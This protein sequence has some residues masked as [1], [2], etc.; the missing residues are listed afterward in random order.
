MI[1]VE[2]LSKS[3]GPHQAV[4]D[5]SF[6]VNQGEIVGFLGPNGAGKSTTL[7]ILA[8][9]LGATSGRVR[10]AGYDIAEE[11]MR[12]RA[13]LGYMP[14]TSPLY[15]EM[16]VSE[17][18][19]FRAE[20]KLV[21]RRA[22]RDAVARALRDARVEDVASVMIGHLSK[23][24]RQRVGLADALVGDPPLLILDEPTAGLDPNQIREVRALVRRLGRDRT[25]LLST[26]I[27]S[28][29]EATCTRAVVIARG[30]LVAEGSIDELRAMRRASGVRLVVRG[31]ADAALAAARGAA[32]VRSAEAEPAGEAA[33]ITVEFDAAAD[34]GEATER[35]VRALVGAG[36]GVRELV[37]HAPSLEQVFSELTAGDDGGEQGAAGG[38]AAPGPVGGSE[39]P[40]RASRKKGSAG[41]RGTGG[42]EK[43][44]R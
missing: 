24:Y 8:G 16:R 10:V 33:R 29:V 26:H 25:V 42:T 17:Y 31:A 13:S 6:R 9:F 30:R 15:P 4:S 32:D 44:R 20:L 14:E 19:A 38:P 36:I 18:L 7:R 39:A 22:R 35:L 43:E 23:G 2:H 1:E 11:P 34:P 3:Y 37:P 41:R 28:E 27:L 12:A 40:P 21:P 5:L